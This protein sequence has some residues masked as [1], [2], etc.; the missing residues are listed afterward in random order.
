MHI[1]GTA[2]AN[3][4]PEWWYDIVDGLPNPVVKNGFI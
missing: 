3:G 4:Q 2:G 1:E